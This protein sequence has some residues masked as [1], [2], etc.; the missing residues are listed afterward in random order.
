MQEGGE[1]KV[2]GER[3]KCVHFLSCLVC[4]IGCR[5]IQRQIY[6][7][8]LNSGRSTDWDVDSRS[9]SPQVADKTIMPK[10]GRGK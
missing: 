9:S 8:F 2:L 1:D 3:R 7:K 5:E 6:C 4:L 10:E